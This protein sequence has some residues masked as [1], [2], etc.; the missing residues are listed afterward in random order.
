[1]KRGTM[2]RAASIAAAIAVLGSCSLLGG[3]VFKVMSWTPGTDYV[4]PGRIQNFSFTFSAPA[5]RTS[6]ETA[7]KIAED[8]VALDGTF[9]WNGDTVVFTPLSPLKAYADY[10]ILIGTGASGRDQMSLVRDFNGKVTTRSDHV[11]PT[12]LSS[13][14]ADRST[15]GS[16]RAPITVA[17]DEP[18][19]YASFIDNCSIDPSLSGRWTASSDFRSYSFEQ[20]EDFANA[21]SYLVKVSADLEDAQGNR[22]GKPYS[23]GFVAGT[24][25]RAPLLSRVRAVAA[26]GSE[27]RQIAWDDAADG[28]SSVTAGWE[29]GWRL[30]LEFDEPIKASRMSVSS[31]SVTPSL[32]MEMEP[33]LESESTLFRFK[34]KDRPAWG[35]EYR[36]ILRGGMED[37]RGNKND[38]SMGFRIVADAPNSRPPELIGFWIPRTIGSYSNEADWTWN[39][40][41]PEHPY[42]T[43][44]LDPA[45]YVNGSTVPT[46]IDVYL[47]LAAGATIDAFESMRDISL[48]G[49]N[50]GVYVSLQ[51]IVPN[52]AP[53][54]TRYGGQYACVRMEVN[55]KL[56][57]NPEIVL[58]KIASGYS[59]S[60]GNPTAAEIRV[61]LIK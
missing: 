29:A 4:E 55:M 10:S 32:S 50:S 28:V 1:M 20:L 54:V 59:D 31:L 18:I 57:D 14:P 22:M 24:D 12:A 36:F 58:F 49:E 26:D 23:W 42:S 45:Y 5:D 43:L 44:E 37:A 46:V 40:Y 34:L 48:E 19:P 13:A 8:G 61:P 56:A 7:L 2:H 17:F 53:L 51:R 52:A 27:A 35:S 47:R 41:T 3:K 16:V 33:V 6:V 38:G 30:E 39:E 25:T 60:A 11:R 15:V 21:A 9:S